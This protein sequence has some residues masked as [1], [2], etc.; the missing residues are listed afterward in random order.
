[1]TAAAK[2]QPERAATLNAAIAL[3]RNWRSKRGAAPGLR[4]SQWKQK[5]DLADDLARIRHRALAGLSENADKLVAVLECGELTGARF[6]EWPTAIFG[7]STTEGYAWELTFANGKCGNDRA[8]GEFR[9]LR[10]TELPDHYVSQMNFWIA[11]ARSAASEGRLHT[12]QDTLESLMRRV[13]K[14]LFPRRTQTQHPTLSSTRHAA[15]ARFKAAYVSTTATEEEKLLGLAM[16][17][18]LLGHASDASA[19]AHYARADSRNGRYPVPVPDALEVA[20]VRRRYHQLSLGKEPS[21]DTSD[22][23]QLV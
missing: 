7:P 22:T 8:H 15:A 19:T 17:A 12:L 16:V 4:T 13:T 5:S 2:L 11:V 20:R 1:M 9:T 21:A 10:W 23:D 18:A 14:A 3:L 6:V